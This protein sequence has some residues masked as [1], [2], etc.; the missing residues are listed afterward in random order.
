MSAETNGNALE[1]KLRAGEVRAQAPKASP[2]VLASELAEILQFAS[3]Q[4]VSLLTCIVAEQPKDSVNLSELTRALTLTRATEGFEPVVQNTI[5]HYRE[6]YS[7][8]NRF[9][10]KK[11]VSEALRS[12]VLAGF[13][14]L[15]AKAREDLE[16]L[17]VHVTEVPAGTSL[18]PSKHQVVKRF[19]TASTGK[20]CTVARCVMPE[21]SWQTPFGKARYEPAQVWAFTELREPKELVIAT[22][23]AKSAPVGISS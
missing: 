15:L 2:K 21:F 10:H 5:R 8:V 16:L 20:L 4:F 13:E 23:D 9:R 22:P 18:N 17:S 11:G 6:T 14:R 19:S 12:D 3:K 1:S 7:E